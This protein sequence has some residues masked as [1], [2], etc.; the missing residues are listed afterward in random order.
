MGTY[1]IYCDESCHLEKDGEKAMTLGAVWCPIDKSGKIFERI[2]DIKEK[3]GFLRNYEIKWHKLSPSKL[4][5]YLDII[6][7][8]FDEA[9]LH[10]RTLVVPD[11]SLL[12]HKSHGQTHDDFYYKMCF[13]LLKIILDPK[14]HYYIYLDYK[15]SQGDVRVVKLREALC[16]RHY[17]FSRTIIKDIQQV[18]SE[19][20]VLVQVSDVLTGAMAAVFNGRTTSEAKLGVIEKIR[21]R[22]RYSL[23]KTTLFKETKFNIFVWDCNKTRTR[24]N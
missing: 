16:N 1:N 20:V 9:D 23:L 17:D 11:K 13:D 8:F 10:F 24:L 12:D 2:K 22:S 3:H 19:D 21:E 6:D 14:S 7:Y 5:L 18:R 15:D 4:A